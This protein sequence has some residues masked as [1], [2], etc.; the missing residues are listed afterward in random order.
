M[1]CA[2]CRADLTAYL[3]G[4]LADDRGSAMRGHLRGCAACRAVSDD[5]GALRDGL[6]ELPAL[7][8]PASLWAGVQAQLAAAEAKDAETPAWRRALARWWPSIPRYAFGA[9]AC[10][11]IAI[12][13]LQLR[14]KHEDEPVVAAVPPPAPVVAKTPDVVDAS[15]DLAAEPA[16]IAATYQQTADELLAQTAEIQKEWTAA[17]RAQFATEVAQ[18]RTAATSRRGWEKLIRYLGNALT[19]DDVALAGG[20][21]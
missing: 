4:E 3:D 14:G 18:L 21:Q 16:R 12:V 6:R 9:V 7:D 2:D 17:Q 5:E 1:S 20:G 11:A 8:P 10:A 19:R 13:V 15:D